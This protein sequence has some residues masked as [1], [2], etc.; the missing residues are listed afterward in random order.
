MSG[1]KM[2]MIPVSRNCSTYMLGLGTILMVIGAALL[3]VSDQRHNF[4]SSIGEG[5]MWLGF[6]LILLSCLVIFFIAKHMTN[7]YNNKLAANSPSLN[8]H[9][10]T[11]E[12]H[13][14]QT[15]PNYTS[16]Q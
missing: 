13:L 5:I 4:P 10:D 9:S 15:N 11:A 3:I 12:S 7:I 14:I 16:E 1:A 8:A 2:C 6:A